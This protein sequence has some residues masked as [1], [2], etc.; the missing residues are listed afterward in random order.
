MGKVLGGKVQSPE[1]R[2]QSPES[3]VQG[4]GSRVQG[5]VQLLGY[6]VSSLTLVKLFTFAA[7]TQARIVCK[8]TSA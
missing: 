2:V 6:T 7:S 3:R 1:S 4:P 5:P 8:S